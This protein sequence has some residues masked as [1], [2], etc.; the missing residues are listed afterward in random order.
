VEDEHYAALSA[1]LRERVACV[2]LDWQR[3]Y[4]KKN[5]VFK[6]ITSWSDDDVS[7]VDCSALVPPFS[8]EEFQT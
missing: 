7:G 3:T 2:E 5:V 1:N 4:F 6:R 8:M